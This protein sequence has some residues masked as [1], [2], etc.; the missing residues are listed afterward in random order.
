[1]RVVYFDL[2][3]GGLIPE[4]HAITQMAAVVVDADWN[5]VEEFECKIK[6]KQELADPEALI[7]NHFDADVWERDGISPFAAEKLFTALLRRYLDLENISKKGRR[8]KSTQMAG[9]N[10]TRFDREF[11]GAWYK[12]LGNKYC[13]GDWRCLDTLELAKWWFFLRDIRPENFQLGP[14]CDYFG[15]TLTGDAHDALVD[16]RASIELAKVLTRE[17]TQMWRENHE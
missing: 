7:H 13:P 8:Y 4:K 12:K 3:T 16:V 2:E 9:H 6:F 17:L 11:L 1:M 15:I 14:L 10:V 5:E